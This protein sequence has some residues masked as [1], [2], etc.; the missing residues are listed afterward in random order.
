MQTLAKTLRLHQWSKNI[1]VVLPMLMAHHFSD[2]RR[3]LDVALALAAFCL[4]ASGT[5]V[6]ND[7]LDRDSDRRHPIKRDRPIA[8][9]EMAPTRA[10]LLAAACYAGGFL[11]AL[12]LPPRV[13]LCLLTYLVVNV[14]YSLVLKR[15]LM[16]DVL[17]LAALYTLRLLAG[18]AAAQV[19]LSLWLLAFSMFLFLDL[20]FIKR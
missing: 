8:S 5:Y 19:P 6:C 7:L 11:L 13:T 17:T 20:A 10:M 18:G 16:L 2:A 4:V 3:W 12:F 14:L 9:G 1:L 15:K